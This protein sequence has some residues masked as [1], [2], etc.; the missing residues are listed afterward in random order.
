[1]RH[2]ALIGALVALIV[3]IACSAQAAPVKDKTGKF[4]IEIPSGWARD[5]GSDL[6]DLISSD[7]V[8]HINVSADTAPKGMS[9]SQFEATYVQQAKQEIKGFNLVTHGKTKIGGLPAGVWVYTGILNGHKLEFKNY[10]T[11]KNGMMYNTIMAT[12][13]ALFKQNAAGLDKL[14][15]SWK[16]L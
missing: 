7:Q 16:W 9:L 4:T 2:L 12:V 3:G 6:F 8:G 5:H 1:M 13:P 14:V 10:I 11:F 15:A